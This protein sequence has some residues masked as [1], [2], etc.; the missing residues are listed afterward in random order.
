LRK[1]PG[2]S[3]LAGALQYTLTRWDALI[4]YAYDGRCDISN[5]AAEGAIRP[6][7][8]GRKDRLFA[9]SDA[10]GDRAAA[11]YSLI[12]CEAERA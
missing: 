6:L 11:I 3:D 10:G 9:G 7:A 2:K 5:N 12:V 8:I 1:I 4:C